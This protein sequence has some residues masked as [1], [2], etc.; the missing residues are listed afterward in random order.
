M[1]YPSL[2]VGGKNISRSFRTFPLLAVFAGTTACDNIG[3]M[4]AYTFIVLFL[5]TIIVQPNSVVHYFSLFRFHSR[6][7]RYFLYNDERNG[8]S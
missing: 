4:E 7:R 1:A 3:S 6:R 5:L 8:K 2:Q